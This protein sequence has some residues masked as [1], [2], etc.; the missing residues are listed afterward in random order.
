MKLVKITNEVRFLEGGKFISTY[1]YGDGETLYG[2][3]LS[4]AWDKLFAYVG[5]N[6]LEVAAPLREIHMEWNIVDSPEEVIE[7]QIPL[8]DE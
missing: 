3:N 4:T 5:K 6:N 1:Y 7:M 2:Q 8:I